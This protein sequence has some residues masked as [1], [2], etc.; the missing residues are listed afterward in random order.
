MPAPT[1]LTVGG[2]LTYGGILMVATNAG[3][4]Q[5]YQVGDSFTLFNLNCGAYSSGS[6][7][8]TIQPPPGPG[9]GWSGANLAVNGSIQVV[10]ASAV[11][12]NFTQTTGSGMLPLTV[13]FN[14]TSSGATYWVWNF[15]DG[16]TLLTTSNTNV[17][18]TYT[19]AGS[20]TVMLTAYGPGGTST[21]TV[22]GAVVAT[23]PAAG[24]GVQRLADGTCSRRS[25]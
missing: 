14:N 11:V 9:L 1:R 7:F 25:R 13:T 23:Y 18:H 19:T 24:G 5:A 22:A 17:P 2:T 15:G 3:D 16:G 20:F 12:A 21:K 8:A 4:S 6:S 10:A